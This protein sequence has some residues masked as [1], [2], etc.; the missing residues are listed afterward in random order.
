M[1][2]AILHSIG[3]ASAGLLLGLFEITGA[4][5]LDGIWGAFRPTFAVAVFVL[6]RNNPKNAGMFLLFAGIATDVFS[7]GAG[8][9]ATAR[10]FLIFATLALLAKTVLTNHSI[11]VALALAFVARAIDLATLAF[12]GLAPTLSDAL[13]RGLWDAALVAALFVLHLPFS[14]RFFQR[15]SEPVRYG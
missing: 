11:Y 5:F 8:T 12:A 10:Y 1:F 3:W 14:R 7:V 2:R 9:F 15:R 4:T 6:I 13:L